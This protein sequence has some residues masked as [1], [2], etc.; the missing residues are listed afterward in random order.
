VVYLALD[1]FLADFCGLLRTLTG[2]KPPVKAAQQA[3]LVARHPWRLAKPPYL[4]S[5]A[6]WAAA[7]RAMG[8]RKGEQLT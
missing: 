2:K 5:S 3:G 1:P 6:A 8:T 7:R 4:S